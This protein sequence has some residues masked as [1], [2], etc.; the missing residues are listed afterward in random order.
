MS[1]SKYKGY[2]LFADPFHYGHK[3]ISFLLGADCSHFVHRLYQLFGANY[4][5][6]KTRHFISLAQAIQNGTSL[7]N[8]YLEKPASGFPIDMPRCEWKGFV[9]S[10][11]LVGEGN[12]EVGD[13]IVFP[14]RVGLRGSNG[15]MGIIWSTSPLRILHSKSR[16]KGIVLEEL[17]LHGVEH[18]VFRWNSHLNPLKAN[19]SIKSL[20]NSKHLSRP[21]KCPAEKTKR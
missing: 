5:Y 3:R 7:D 11:T 4:P 21:F 6:A 2:I 19:S 20:L 12:L 1:D 9:D 14:R 10:F 16:K 13:V 18:F 17:A 15:H 8:Y